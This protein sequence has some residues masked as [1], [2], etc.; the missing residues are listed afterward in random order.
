MREHFYFLVLS[1]METNQLSL[2]DEIPSSQHIPASFHLRDTV[3]SKAVR[4]MTAI[5]SIKSS[6]NSIKFH[7]EAN[8]MNDDGTFS[9]KL[10]YKGR[11]YMIK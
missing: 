5:P 10:S 11:S 3:A 6:I 4:A 8:K 7:S 2:L 1:T 9:C